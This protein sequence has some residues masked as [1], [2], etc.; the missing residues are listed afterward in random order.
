MII[1]W[2]VGGL[3]AVIGMGWFVLQ[4]LGAKRLPATLDPAVERKVRDAFEARSLPRAKLTLQAGVYARGPLDS[5]F[6]GPVTLGPDEQWPLDRQGRAMVFLAQVNFAEMPGLPDFP[7]TGVLQFFIC[8][9]DQF[10][11]DLKDPRNSDV[12]VIWRPDWDGKGLER[13]QMADLT[14]NNPFQTEDLA[15]RGMR[16]A[17]DAQTD[18]MTPTSEDPEISRIL[19]PLVY[20]GSV[21]LDLLVDELNA[22]QDKVGHHVGGHPRFIQGDM[23][24]MSV[25]LGEYDRVLL[26]VSSDQ[27]IAW[28]DAGEAQ[29]MIRREDLLAR[30]FSKS[31]FSWDCY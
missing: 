8:M 19:D 24:E 6:G 9:N 4:L 22:Q 28:G 7:T 1:V 20:A 26:Q 13:P 12:R 17:F 31:T 29:F 3:I 27:L 30:D 18:L 21:S 15:R 23:R 11:A 2:I 16:I 14:G 5:R 10:G 25:D